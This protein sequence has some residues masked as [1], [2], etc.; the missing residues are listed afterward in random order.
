MF[1]I[2]LLI[3]VV[4]AEWPPSVCD[5][6]VDINQQAVTLTSPKLNAVET[7]C[8]MSDVFENHVFIQLQKQSNKKEIDQDSTLSFDIYHGKQS[9]FKLSVFNNR[10]ETS[11]NNY[12]YKCSG[13]FL[14]KVTW[15]KI[16]LHT[17][18]DFDK[19]FVSLSTG[20]SDA[21]T[22]C[23]NFDLQGQYP[24]FKFKI[25]GHTS[26]SLTQRVM[27]I[28][29]K[30]PAKHEKN[31]MI[32]IFDKLTFL[33]NRMDLIQMQIH[34]LNTDHHK[35]KKTVIDTHQDIKKDVLRHKNS[36]RKSNTFTKLYITLSIF[37][38]V[39]LVIGLHCYKNRRN[40]RLHLL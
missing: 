19:T 15:L 28:G 23:F 3:V 14:D 37:T 10:I 7:R 12:P 22:P 25:L 17:F 33:E 32:Q 35:H 26:H 24:F 40:H 6:S 30:D 36:Q 11:Y 16:R 2:F 5:K 4:N 9:L 34:S 39:L 21:F 38:I 8:S 20:D 13:D 27:Y 31:Q 18:D 29:K 1:Y